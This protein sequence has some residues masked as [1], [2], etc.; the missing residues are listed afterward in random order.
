MKN[1]S[2]TEKNEKREDWKY[3]CDRCGKPSGKDE[4]KGLFAIAEADIVMND[5]SSLKL[6]MAPDSDI[7]LWLGRT[8]QV[9]IKK[10][11]GAAYPE[12]ISREEKRIDCC[13]ECF[14]NVVVPAL[15]ELGFKLHTEQ[16]DY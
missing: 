3:T 12:T 11:E 8:K 9:N 10:S 7:Q 15:I 14:E 6:K 5:S 16:L 1:I 4:A 2:I 13:T